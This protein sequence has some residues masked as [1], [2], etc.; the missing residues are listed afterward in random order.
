LS[1]GKIRLELELNSFIR[2]LYG[3]LSP[4]DDD[5]Q[6]IKALRLKTWKQNL[7][8][9][10]NGS[11]IETVTKGG[12]IRGRRKHRVVIDDPEENKD[13]KNAKIAE[14]FKDFVLTSVY[15]MMLPGRE[16]MVVLGTMI[17][18][19]CL[20]KSLIDDEGRDNIK[21]KAIENGKPIRPELRSM[22]ALEARKKKI[23]TK[24]F[25]QEFLHIPLSNEDT[26]VE[27]DRIV[28]KDIEEYPK[29][30][31]RRLMCIDPAQ[32]DKTKND[33]TGLVHL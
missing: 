31:I 1:I 11:S 18:K 26:L 24:R 32:K 28:Q 17:G 5:S 2:E 6:E 23:G 20:V 12:T 8:E 7:L 22:E 30:W 3:P 9:L 10:A 15:N 27:Y 14:A 13:V 21:L 33:F 16:S 19:R 25:N 4:R 29:A